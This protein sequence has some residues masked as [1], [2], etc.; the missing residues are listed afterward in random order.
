MI[1]KKDY[2]ELYCEHSYSHNKENMLIN[3]DWRKV[4]TCYNNFKLSENITI[5]KKI[6]QIWLGGELPEKYR[7]ICDSWKIYNPDWEYF[8][9]TDSDIEKLEFGTKSIFNSIVNLGMK[10]DLVRIEILKIFGGLYADIDFE[11]VKSF[12]DL[13]KLS[14]YTG[15]VYGHNVEVAN[16]LIGSVPNHPIL[17]DYLNNLDYKNGKETS[18][19]IFNTTGPYYFTKVFLRNISLDTEDIVAFPTIYFYPFHNS[20]IPEKRLMGFDKS[21]LELTEKFFTSD[22]YATH[23]WHAGWHP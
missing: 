16:G 23:W 1:E 19:D 20:Y 7:R 15:L 22:T 10:S 21:D 6:H 12:D 8:L 14:F 4:I 18:E 5:P 17:I 9:W 11:C 2:I 13:N 3:E